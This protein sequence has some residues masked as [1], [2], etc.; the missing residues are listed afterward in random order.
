MATPLTVDL[1][2]LRDSLIRGDL[3]DDFEESARRKVEVAE[4][5]LEQADRHELE[6]MMYRTWYETALI[7]DP[8]DSE[9]RIQHALQVRYISLRARWQIGRAHV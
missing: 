2:A 6:Q 4:V 8:A 9:A 7:L 1:F 5:P 3:R